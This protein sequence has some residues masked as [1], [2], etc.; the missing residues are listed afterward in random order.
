MFLVKGAAFYS[1]CKRLGKENTN[2][3]QYG[4]VII[5]FD[6]DFPAECTPL[7]LHGFITIE[8][9][10]LLKLCYCEGMLRL[11]KVFLNAS[12]STAPSKSN[13]LAR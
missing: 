8:C 13:L 2:C 7:L 12:V 10:N 6:I 1:R 4:A 3:V 5:G 9:D 11:T